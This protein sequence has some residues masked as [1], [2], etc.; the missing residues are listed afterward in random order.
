MKVTIFVSMDERTLKDFKYWL[1]V[2]RS[3]SPNTVSAYGR[4]VA[5]FLMKSGCDAGSAKADDINDYLA[6][7]SRDI[8]KRSQARTISALR[9]FFNWTILENIRKDNPCDGVDTPKLGRYLPD[10]LS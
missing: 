5:E 9:S 2:E 10:V 4:D 7:R 1:K 8:G 6:R 3:M